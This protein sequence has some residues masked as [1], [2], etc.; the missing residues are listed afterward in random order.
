M[1]LFTTRDNPVKKS[2]YILISAVFW[3]ALW[4]FASHKVGMKYV[5]PSPA[6]TFRRLAELMGEREFYVNTANSLLSIF[7]GFIGG[8]AI[9]TVLGIGS[10]ALNG[11]D[12]LFSPI[13]TVIKAT[14]VASFI[15]LAFIWMDNSSIPILISVLMIT[16]IVLSSLKTAILNVDNDLK[17]MAQV[18]RMPFFK[19]ITCLYLPSVMPSY[20]TALV[21]AMGLGWKAGIAAEVLC[22]S[23]NTLGN[24]LSEAKR[25]LEVTDQFAYTLAI[26]ILSVAMELI[27][28]Y[29]IRKITAKGVR[30]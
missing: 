6:A 19:K 25:Y 24:E 29:C 26:I 3:T 23:E 18:Y 10:A 20:L 11:V 7:K 5:F 14:P 1:K 30:K 21:T 15:V 13:N 9:G 12:A 16:P 2:I 4:D 17:E 22:G 8:A 28:R 27:F